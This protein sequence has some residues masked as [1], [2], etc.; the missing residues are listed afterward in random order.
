MDYPKTAKEAKEINAH[1]YFTGLECKFGHISLRYTHNGQCVDC[2]KIAGRI[3]RNTPEGKIYEKEYY[4]RIR[5]ERVE[6]IMLNSAKGRARKRNMPCLI[7]AKD[8]L[9]VWPVDDLCPV[10]GIE[11]K[12]NYDKSGG[13]TPNSPSLDCINP[14]LG[15][16]PGNIAVMSQKANLLKGDEIDPE[17][18]R[19]IANWIESQNLLN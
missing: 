4:R 11:L 16:I 2:G 17:I 8:I 19:K 15:Y 1:K 5:T 14:K 10:L 13:H 7:T 12:H 3:A 9:N 18:F 6:Q